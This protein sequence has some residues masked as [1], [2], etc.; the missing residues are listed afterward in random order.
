[1]P[2]NAPCMELPQTFKR[3]LDPLASLLGEA[4]RAAFPEAAPG[5][6]TAAA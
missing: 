2:L 4:V 3:L 5:E 6:A 1:M